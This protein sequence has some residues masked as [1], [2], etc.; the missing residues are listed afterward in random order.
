MVEPAAFAVQADAGAYDCPVFDEEDLIDSVLAV[1]ADGPLHRS[2]MIARVSHDIPELVLEFEGDDA[3]IEHY[4]TELLY[5]TDGTWTTDAGV[6]ASMSWV[7]AGVV[8]TLPLSAEALASG[9]IDLGGDGGLLTDL[10]IPQTVPGA[11]AYAFRTDTPGGRLIGPAGWLDGASSD[12]VV[13]MTFD[14]AELTHALV[15]RRSLGEGELERALIE[16]HLERLRAAERGINDMVLLLDGII[17]SSVDSSDGAGVRLWG[18]AVPPLGELLTDAGFEQRDDEW[19]PV[20]SAWLT[21]GEASRAARDA[22]LRTRFAFDACCD[23]AFDEVLGF[24]SQIDALHE[25]GIEL[26]ELAEHFDAVALQAAADAVT[27]SLVGSALAVR[28]LLRPVRIDQAFS[29]LGWLLRKSDL[30]QLPQAAGAFIEAIEFERDGD[31]LAAAEAAALANRLHPQFRPAAELA[32][33]YAVDRGDLDKA[34]RLATDPN[35][36]SDGPARAI[37]AARSEL[38]SRYV[39]VR[40]N[41]PCPCGSGRRFK[42][43]CQRHPKHTLFDRFRLLDFRLW[44]FANRPHRLERSRSLED[45]AGTVE[46]G[47]DLHGHDAHVVYGGLLPDYLAERGELLS[48]ADRALAEAA[49]ATGYAVVEVVEV[50]DPSSVARVRVLSAGDVADAMYELDTKAEPLEVRE[51]LLGRFLMLDGELTYTGLLVQLE[52]ER[53]DDV[54]EALSEEWD[55]WSFLDWLGATT[56]SAPAM[57]GGEPVVFVTSS[58]R[59]DNVEAHRLAI[60][61]VLSATHSEG[62]GLETGSWF[63]DESAGTFD[64]VTIDGPYIAVHESSVRLH[65]QLMADIAAVVGSDLIELERTD[66][67]LTLGE[68][69][70]L[71]REEAALMEEAADF[72]VGGVDEFDDEWTLGLEAEM[73]PGAGAPDGDDDRPSGGLVLP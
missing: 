34:V 37:R 27:H 67:T 3:A 21:H 73:D 71:Q 31:G 51:C 38:E 62:G 39:G 10:F 5:E 25:E 42:Q 28:H 64:A 50:L 8:T 15:P 17:D 63:R 59:V 40:R 41:D 18:S 23:S 30:G 53:V 26:P 54:I 72:A 58:F 46:S 4:V 60:E 43:C 19:G 52:A 9:E 70:S 6:V 69:R 13:V 57:V 47:V 2:E 44:L 24:L 32:A 66:E 48:D 55:A 33:E 1:L 36:P 14:G 22:E 56:G 49:D 45:M 61:Q 11:E 7:L 20:G 29:D 16:G 68:L 12:D 35:Y 65:D